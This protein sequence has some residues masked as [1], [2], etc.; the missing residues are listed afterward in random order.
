MKRM[1]LL[2]A[3]ILLGTLNIYAQRSKIKT[4]SIPQ[5]EI[6]NPDFYAIL[7][8]FIVEEKQYDYYNTNVTFF[9]NILD[10]NGSV[11]QL[12]S[13]C[14]YQN[15][16]PFVEKPSTDSTLGLFY[17]RTHS[18]VIRGRSIVNGN[19]LIKNKKYCP[20]RV[21]KGSDNEIIIEDDSFFPTTWLVYFDGT[22][23]EIFSKAKMIDYR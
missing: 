17:Y 15:K 11:L 20:V 12:S 3:I 8:S 5:Y 10:S 21:F 6:I 7:D 18:F 2:V 22:N 1:L 4:D 13:G 9:V 14:D 16:A 19:I 23:I